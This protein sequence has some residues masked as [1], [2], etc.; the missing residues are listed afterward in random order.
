VQT[1][2]WWWVIAAIIVAWLGGMVAASW[3]GYEHRSP[4]RIENWKPEAVK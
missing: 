1:R 2:H 3:I 4:Q